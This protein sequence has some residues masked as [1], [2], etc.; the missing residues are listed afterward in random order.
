M[1]H[2]RTPWI[3]AAVVVAASSAP[4][5]NISA[6]QADATYEAAAS[7]TGVKV[8][9]SNQ[10]I[11]LG[12]APQIQGPTAQAKQTSLHQSDAYAAFP[13]PGEEVAGFPGV[14][15]GTVGIPAPAYPF[16]VST[17]YGD[18]VRRLNYPGIELSSESGETITQATA[19]G[20]SKGIGLTSI[21]RISRDGDSVTATAASDA[22][23][24]RLG[25]SLV[26]NGLRAAAGA[27]RDT[28]GKLVR[29]SSLSFS[30]LSVPGLALAVPA[31]P[32][33]A[34]PPQKLTA[35]QIGFSDGTFT[36]TLPGAPTSVTP[37]PAKDVLAAFE[38]AGYHITYQAPQDTADGII[39][40]GLQIATTLPAP[41]PGSPAGLSGQTPV[42]FSIGLAR[43]EI[44]YR[45][46]SDTGAGP[47]SSEPVAAPPAQGYG[48]PP[49]AG[50][51][52]GSPAA[53]VPGAGAG[54][55]ATV[56][57]ASGVSEATSAQPV[58]LASLAA[59]RTPL[60]T[61]IG[62]LYLMVAAIGGAG[63]ASIAA[64]RWAGGRG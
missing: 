8:I 42:T 62:W 2:R 29:T 23:G 15:G 55:T 47:S 58:R 36:V 59:A 57:H 14:L 4:F 26:L 10:S 35:P 51:P 18:D 48:T 20:G 27:G 52:A 53:A 41:P 24:L 16:V 12:V 64:L 45:A 39:G 50:L 43:A 40:A 17:A 54:M 19:T 38:A 28:T 61:D 22:D 37:L 33:S 46:S 11:P 9:F 30:S 1:A 21:A 6:A 7:A 56:E 3:V 25:D 13:Y 31:P 49:A 32:G 63:L 5:L 34:G 60:H 44:S